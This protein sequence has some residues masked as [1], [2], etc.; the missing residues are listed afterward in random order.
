MPSSSPMS[1]NA[2][3]SPVGR[4]GVVLLRATNDFPGDLQEVLAPWVIHRHGDG[5]PG[6]TPTAFLVIE[7]TDQLEAALAEG[8]E[9]GI[10]V[11][12]LAGD[13]SPDL[14]ITA[15]ENGLFAHVA[16]DEG[17]AWKKLLP[18]QLKRAVARVRER[19]HT[20][21]VLD[22]LRRR[23]DLY[24]HAVSAAHVGV[25]DWDLETNEL[26]IEANLKELLGYSD[27][28]IRNNLNDWM[29]HI[30]PADYRMVMESAIACR[31]EGSTTYEVEYRVRHRNGSLRWLYVRGA[32]RETA[33][34][35]RILGAT[36][37][38]TPLKQ[39]EEAL[40]EAEKR[41]RAVVDVQT[42][43]I[44]RTRRTGKITFVN[45]A[46]ARFWC[47]TPEELI[48]RNLLDLL[49]EDKQEQARNYLSSFSP[50]HTRKT[51]LTEVPEKSGAKRW[52][53][54]SSNAIYDE[55]GNLLEIQSVGRDVTEQKLAREE[56]LRSEARLRQILE[57]LPA[58]VMLVGP[59]Y[60]IRYTNSRFRDVFGD[61]GDQPCHKVLHGSDT[62]CP[63]CRIT[64]ALDSGESS[65]CEL[66]T[67]DGRSWLV[68]DVLYKDPEGDSM[69]V[70]IGLDISSHVETEKALLKTRD[71][72]HRVV[73]HCP[74]VLFALD[75]D[76]RFTLSEG[77]GL[78][79]LGLEP[80]QVVGQ[81][82]ME[83]Y[84][85][86]QVVL[87]QLKRALAGEAFSDLSTAGPGRTYRIWFS[88]IIDS[89]GLVCGTTGVA[90]DITEWVGGA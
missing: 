51:E 9:R 19:H 64:R 7:D 21:E 23:H 82:A 41:Y 81:S 47:T 88:P 56:T 78:A 89:E 65:Q 62:P 11:L 63:D 18:I 59:D 60:S 90:L 33:G 83:L 24:H 74:I 26:H 61:P 71:D 45:M 76:G 4:Q 27:E 73:G 12:L 54:W 68:H 77:A 2:D 85:D 87:D 80:G 79:A 40:L 46:F 13:P 14:L 5:D 39:A 84:K 17:G 28:E 48:G 67:P 10:P 36:T 86:N 43:L 37:D 6:P 38:I 3:R 72:L 50:Q 57:L 70:E 58:F 32:L 22:T 35:R 66:T 8:N 49:P 34:R 29:R 53:R 44:C 20:S 42:E 30:H 1:M 52:I 31:D 69:V 75:E 15:F 16:V 55:I 25:W